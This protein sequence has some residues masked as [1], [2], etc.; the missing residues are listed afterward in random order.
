MRDRPPVP[1]TGAGEAVRARR[2]LA[3]DPGSVQSAWVRVNLPPGEGP[4][5]TWLD[6]DGQPRQVR[7]FNIT[8]NETVADIV[9]RFNPLC[10]DDDRRVII[11]DVK[12]YGVGPSSPVV[13]ESVIETAKWI[14]E[15]RRCYRPAGVV[16]LDRRTIKRAVCGKA[17]AKDKHVRQAL[18]DLYGGSKRA[19]VGLKASPGPLYGW[20]SHLWS[21]LAVAVAYQELLRDGA[22]E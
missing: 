6:L 5:L 13:G 2:L 22:L 15:F 10:S 4:P 11:E 20:K 1:A 16:L 9:R 19:A 18:I 12:L 7:E 8:A 17:N 14:G 3:I 21:A